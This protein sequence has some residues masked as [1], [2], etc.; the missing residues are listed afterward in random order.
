[1]FEHADAGVEV[2]AL[3]EPTMLDHVVELTVE[4]NAYRL[5]AQQAIH[6]CHAQHVELSRLR[7]SRERLIVELRA[8]RGQ[9]QPPEQR[10]WR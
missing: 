10:R 3:D 8:L 9:M 2:V 5:L 6:Y 4:R 7:A 1:M